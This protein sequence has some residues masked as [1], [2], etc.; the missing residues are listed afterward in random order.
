MDK[1]KQPELEKALSG[2]KPGIGIGAIVGFEW[3]GNDEVGQKES[4]IAIGEVICYKIVVKNRYGN[5]AKLEA[6]A[7][8]TIR[9]K[10]G[11]FVELDES[12][13]FTSDA[14]I[15]MWVQKYTKSV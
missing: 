15:L 7:L 8:Y 10:G 5:R 4:C 6:V 3:K 1:P 13:I 11:H 2:L 9:T 14:Q 12:E